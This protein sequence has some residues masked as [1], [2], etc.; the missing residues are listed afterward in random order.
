MR[1]DRLLSMLLMISK[2]GM[3]TGKELAEHFEVS[4]RTIYR[5]IEKLGEAGIPIASMGG[6]GGGFYVM[7]NY[8]VDNLFLKKDEASTFMAIMNNLSFLFGK[9]TNF[10]DMVLK[11]ENTYRREI[12]TDKL[13]INMSHFSM[14]NELKEYLF[15]MNNAIEENKLLVFDYSNRRMDYSERIV[16]PV[17]ITF[18]TGQWYLVA[19]CRYRSDYRRFKLVRISHLKMGDGFEKRDISKEELEKIFEESYHR[20]SIQVTLKFTNRMGEQLTEYFQKENIQKTEDNE[21]VVIDHFPYEDGLLKYILSFGKECEIVEPRYLRDEF[22]E[23][24]KELWLTYH[25]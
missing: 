25:D 6:K 16:E 23:Y 24:I 20:R 1:V 14:E 11:I 17:Q 7:E 12:N 3:V 2:K 18:S 15:L 5:D 22:K 19:F 9:S 10:N 21:Y 13:S 4:L 8:N